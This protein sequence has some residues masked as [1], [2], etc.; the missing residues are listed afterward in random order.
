LSSIYANVEACGKA[1]KFR[2]L[3]PTREY[4]TGP[5]IHNNGL[6][7]V[8]VEKC[9]NEVRINEFL[10]DNYGVY[11]S[12]AAK[13]DFGYSDG[14]EH[15][16]FIL[17]A[18][19]STRDVS[20]YSEELRSMIKDWPS[21][22]HFSMER[23]NLLRHVII[24]PEMSI[25]ELGCGCG[26]ITRQLGESGAKVTAVE[27]SLRRARSA[28]ARCRDLENVKVYCSNFQ[29]VEFTEKYD[30]VTL[31]GFSNTALSISNQKTQLKSVLKLQAG[32]SR[33]MAYWSLQLKTS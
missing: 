30:L 24:R 26:A 21:E 1:A 7:L 33:L 6:S 31:I 3:L 20:L 9:S 14:A 8:L 10:Q 11:V 25:L 13:D 12:S 32:H 19:A 2:G 28:A 22:Y 16:D 17:A 27:G 4:D 18:L 29:D 23:H 15:E 5:S